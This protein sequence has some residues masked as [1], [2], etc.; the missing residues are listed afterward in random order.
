MIG[1][2]MHIMIDKS[3]CIDLPFTTNNKLLCDV[4]VEQTIYNKFHHNMI[5]GSLNL[6][7]LLLPPYYREV[8]DYKS[9]DPLCIQRA[10]SSVNWVF[11][12][13]TAD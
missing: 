4:G 12:N 3:S 8:W 5:Y 13:K 1:Q 7:I 2:A 11:S 6:N 10:I 9:T